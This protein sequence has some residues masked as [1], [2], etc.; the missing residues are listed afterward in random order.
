MMMMRDLYSYMLLSALWI[1]LQCA[2]VLGF[3]GLRHDAYA[4]A[5]WC[6]KEADWASKNL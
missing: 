6:R 5:E 2:K 4:L 1:G 3:V